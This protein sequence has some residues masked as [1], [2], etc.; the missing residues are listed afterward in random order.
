MNECNN[1]SIIFYRFEKNIL[2]LYLQKNKEDKYTD[3]KVNNIDISIS[4]LYKLSFDNNII[5][6][7]DIDRYN[8][9]FNNDLIKISFNTFIKPSIHKYGKI[10]KLKNDEIENIL[11]KI[12][13]NYTIH[14]KIK[15]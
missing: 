7:L 2:Y 12:K 13:L 9:F 8:S 3:I 11:T 15:N 6:F 5:Y 4:P 14:H 1:I 10:N